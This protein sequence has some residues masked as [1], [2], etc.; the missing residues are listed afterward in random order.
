MQWDER[1]YGSRVHHVEGERSVGSEV[2]SMQSNPSADTLDIVFVCVCI[3]TVTS[4]AHLQ[5]GPSCLRL[6][7]FSW[8]LQKADLSIE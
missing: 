7:G 3:V 5:Q 4:R 6:Q 8:S 2:L 1:A